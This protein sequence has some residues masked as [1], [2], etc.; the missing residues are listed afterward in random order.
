MPT[1]E[2]KGVSPVRV[3]PEEA[4]ESGGSLAEAKP[5]QTIEEL[6][7]WLA[8]RM[9]EEIGE[10]YKFT[11]ITVEPDGNIEANFYDNLRDV[12]TKILEDIKESIEDDIIAY[13]RDLGETFFKAKN[14]TIHKDGLHYIVEEEI[15]RWVVRHVI[16][17]VKA[18]YRIMNEEI[19]NSINTSKLYATI[20]A[21]RI[22]ETI[23]YNIVIPRTVIRDMEAELKFMIGESP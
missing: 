4:R 23:F 21:V 2:P 19:L 15:G 8:K 13:F 14:I 12:A 11:L 10:E 16:K 22:G 18:E 20:E 5:P 6:D 1:P 9:A 7:V 3:E 17:A